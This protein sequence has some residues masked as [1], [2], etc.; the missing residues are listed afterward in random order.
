MAAYSGD[1]KRYQQLVTLLRTMQKI[2][3]GAKVVEEIVADWKM[4]YR[5]RP[6]MMDELRKL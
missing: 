4:Q 6:A 3:G 2:N 1:R 5:N